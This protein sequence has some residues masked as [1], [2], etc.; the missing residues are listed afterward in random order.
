RAELSRLRDLNVWKL[1]QELVARQNAA[2]ITMQCFARQVQAKV[3]VSR[4]KEVEIK[5]QQDEN[6]RLERLA[7][8]ERVLELAAICVQKSVRLF[9]A[10]KQL[11]S[12]QQAKAI[13]QMRYSQSVVFIQSWIRCVQCRCRYRVLQLSRL[14]AE[15]VQLL[16]D[17]AREQ[18]GVSKLR[19]LFARAILKP[20][21]LHA[22]AVLSSQRQAKKISA[23]HYIVKLW[24]LKTIPQCLHK[25][26]MRWRRVVVSVIMCSISYM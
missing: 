8:E 23:Q 13:E 5:L 18:L 10:H 1:Q 9:L 12:L 24:K 19:K 7:V 26:L 16:K 17:K 14:A 21:L 2:A 20:L 3:A 4:Y 6:K 22:R 25:F 11:L 15:D